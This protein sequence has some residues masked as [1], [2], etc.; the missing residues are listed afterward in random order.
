[1]VFRV[2]LSRISGYLVHEIHQIVAYERRSV[3]QV[4]GVRV[5][6]ERR[7]FLHQGM[8]IPFFYFYDRRQLVGEVFRRL[9]YFF[10]L[11]LDSVDVG[12]SF[13]EFAFEKFRNFHFSIFVLHHRNHLFDYQCGK[14]LLHVVHNLAFR[15]G[16][17]FALRDVLHVQEYRRRRFLVFLFEKLEPFVTRGDVIVDVRVRLLF[18]D[19]VGKRVEIQYVA[20]VILRI[21]SEIVISYG[22]RVFYGSHMPDYVLLDSRKLFF[23]LRRIV[24]LERGILVSES[25]KDHFVIA[26]SV[27]AHELPADVS[28]VLCVLQERSHLLKFSELHVFEIRYVSIVEHLRHRRSVDERLY[29]F[30]RIRFG[31]VIVL[32]HQVLFHFHARVRSDYS[33]TSRAEVTVY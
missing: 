12:H 27:F 32:A 26:D 24:N 7:Y 14:R 20:P 15:R 22:K 3:L 9:P 1:M 16:R 10:D 2:L 23:Q 18:L 29:D 30:V 17:S 25:S 19:E 21:A 6:D 31:R 5:F 33:F 13:E 8:E 4:F 28:C 11:L